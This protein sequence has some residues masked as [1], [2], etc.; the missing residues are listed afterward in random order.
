MAKKR[1]ILSRKD[2][3]KVVESDT[4]ETQEDNPLEEIP[5]VDESII[6][7]TKSED[8]KVHHKD[9]PN[10]E[11]VPKETPDEEVKDVKK[12]KDNIEKAIDRFLKFHIG[13]SMAS[14][15]GALE[16][17]NLVFTLNTVLTKNK[18][19]EKEATR[20]VNLLT[21]SVIDL[22][23]TGAC[24]PHWTHDNSSLNA[25]TGL[26]AIVIAKQKGLPMTTA[27]IR[28]QF[29]GKFAPL[30]EALKT[31]HLKQPRTL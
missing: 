5:N 4:L 20:I 3:T 15:Q 17:Y 18:N 21:H 7:P 10:A 1:A 30:G 23:K 8:A 2:E 31:V 22:N 29:N 12:K 28:R 27:G 16:A 14:K 9:K 11:P 19:K 25:F 24:A 6:E 13:N 26:I